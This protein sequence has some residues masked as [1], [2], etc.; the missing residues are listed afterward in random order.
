LELC[1]PINISA[2]SGEDLDDYEYIP[3]EI[4]GTKTGIQ[5]NFLST[6]QDTVL[7]AMF[8][9][10]NVFDYL[11]DKNDLIIETDVQEKLKKVVDNLRK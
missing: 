1:K 8:S 11:L 5:S 7:M 3:H 10:T 9:F 2:L 6:F 4:I